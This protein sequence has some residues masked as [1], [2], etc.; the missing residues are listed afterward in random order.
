MTLN[1]TH[2]PNVKDLKRDWFIVD[3]DGL[4][5]GRLAVILANRLRGK[6][7]PFFTPN[8]QCGDNIIVV[9]CEKVLL[10]GQK[11]EKK[12]YYWHTGYPGG[13]KSVTP[14]KILEGKNPSRVIELAVKRMI[15]KGPLG[16][17]ILKQLHLF[18]G[19]EHKYE[20]QKPLNIDVK[21]MNRKN[22]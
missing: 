11:K 15:P 1:K 17:K 6:H 16:R 13:I 19:S 14:E 4:V 12:Q 8:M 22:S 21:S 20:A 7:K 9:N 5:L 18:K 2:M 3:A 10:T